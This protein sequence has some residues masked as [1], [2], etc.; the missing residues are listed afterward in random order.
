MFVKLAH[1]LI[2]KMLQ[3]CSKEMVEGVMKVN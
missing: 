3:S 2:R 1:M